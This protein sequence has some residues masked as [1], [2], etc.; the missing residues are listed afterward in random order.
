M[1]LSN[2]DIGGKDK[3]LTI[4]KYY[5]YNEGGSVQEVGARH[6]NLGWT[7]GSNPYDRCTLYMIR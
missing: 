4:A 5:L 3:I 7:W 1:R 6:Q 2:S